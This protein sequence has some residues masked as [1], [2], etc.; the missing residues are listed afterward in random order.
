M[1]QAQ[2]YAKLFPV[3]IPVGTT[4]QTVGAGQ[5]GQ[6]GLSPLAQIG[7]LLAGIGSFMNTGSGTAGTSGT[8]TPAQASSIA[9]SILSL[10]SSVFGQ[11]KSYL[12]S[13][14]INFKE[15][16]K[17]NVPSHMHEHLLR[18]KSMKA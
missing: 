1:L 12:N 4:E 18:I 17:V 11:A 13:L 2:N 8:A 9:N 15:G 7:S 10:P 6:Y 16:G 5:A 14:G 3:S